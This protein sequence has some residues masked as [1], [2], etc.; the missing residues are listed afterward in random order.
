[1]NQCRCI[2]LRS[3]KHVRLPAIR[4]SVFLKR[5]WYLQNLHVTQLLKGLCL[6]WL[7]HVP[8]KHLHVHVCTFFPSLH[9]TQELL[10]ESTKDFLQL[11]FEN[12]NK[13]KSWMLEKDHLMSKIKE[14]RV[15]CK[16]KEEKMG[17]MWLVHES[18]HNQNEY[19]K[20]V[21]SILQNFFF[22]SGVI[23]RT[24]RISKNLI[25]VI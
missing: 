7:S 13:E 9:H 12:Q 22:Y 2:I 6:K 10:Y 8:R 14:Y 5:W 19:I 25:I 11:R 20:V 23:E 15:Q 1:M 16:K 21:S 18:H 24:W 17:K 3:V 4:W